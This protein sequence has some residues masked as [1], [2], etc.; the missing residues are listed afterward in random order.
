MYR[1]M[2]ITTTKKNVIEKKK[3][4][5]LI[6][7]HGANKVDNYYNG[8]GEGKK[9]KRFYRTSQKII[10]NVFLESLL[11]K[12]FP[13]LGVT[14]HHTFLGCADLWTCCGGSSDSNLVILLCV[15]AFNV[16]S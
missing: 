8:G 1:Q 6:G 2:F 4:K 9:S 13:S 16:H 12:S 14:V 7:F 3:L 5:S 15:L 11:S 10:I